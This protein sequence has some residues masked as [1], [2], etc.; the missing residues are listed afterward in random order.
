LIVLDASAAVELILRT[1]RSDRIA[2]RVLDPTQRL[3][4]PE[5]IDIEVVQVLRRLHLAK[6]LTLERAGIAVSDFEH[7]A[8]ERHPHRPL[9]R[10]VWALRSM[11]SAYDSAYV[12]LAE[13]LDAPLVTCDERLSRAHGHDARIELIAER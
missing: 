5:L 1:P 10:R 13:A 11:M 2:A 6:E 3:H 4:A 8:V 7:L 9:M 12:A